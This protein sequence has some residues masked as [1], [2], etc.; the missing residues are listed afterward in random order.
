MGTRLAL[1]LRSTVTI[2]VTILFCLSIVSGQIDWA[3][4]DDD[5]GDILISS[6][7]FI[8][9]FLCFLAAILSLCDHVSI[10]PDVSHNNHSIVWNLELYISNSLTCVGCKPTN[11]GKSISSDNMRLLSSRKQNIKELFS[12]KNTKTIMLYSSV[13]IMHTL[14]LISCNWLWSSQIRLNFMILRFPSKMNNHANNLCACAAKTH[15]HLYRPKLCKTQTILIDSLLFFSFFLFPYQNFVTRSHTDKQIH[16]YLHINRKL[17]STP[18]YRTTNIEILITKNLIKIF[19][20]FSK[21]LACSIPESIYSGNHTLVAI[22]DIRLSCRFQCLQFRLKPFWGK[23]LHCLV[24]LSQRFEMIG[25]TWFCGS[26]K[27]LENHCTGF[28]SVLI[29]RL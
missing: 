25:Y 23:L 19:S 7:C 20:N 27:V 1:V 13:N 15:T 10:G 4:D 2:S 11:K 9:K 26:E 22:R 29:S 6:V 12:S 5:P 24:I 21:S 28:S 18:H 3:D 8:H 16:I 17:H 14:T